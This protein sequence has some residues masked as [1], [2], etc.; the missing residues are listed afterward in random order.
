MSQLIY[1]PFDQLHRKFGALKSAD[2]KQDVIVM[3]ESARMTT[4]RNWH[5]QRLHFLISSAR[6]FAQSLRDEGFTVEYVKAPTTIDGLT[7]FQKKYTLKLQ[8]LLMD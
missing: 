3:V 8:Q 4:G 1:L 6:H 7:N 5:P 2:P